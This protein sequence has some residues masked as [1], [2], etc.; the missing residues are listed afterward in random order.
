MAGYHVVLLLLTILLFQFMCMCNANVTFPKQKR[1][2][3]TNDLGGD[4]SLA[5]TC[6]SNK[7]GDLGLHV[8]PPHRSYEYDFRFSTAI[9]CN[10]KWTNVFHEFNIF[11][12]PREKPQC[13]ETTCTVSWSI[14][15]SGPCQFNP[16]TKK[17]DFCFKWS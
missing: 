17:Y 14:L 12:Q 2:V 3:V 10:W 1:V 13:T 5:M 8:L 7:E 6:N 16:D 9:Y 4:L 11:V 15:P